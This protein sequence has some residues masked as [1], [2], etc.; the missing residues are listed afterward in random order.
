[1]CPRLWHFH[2][3]FRTENY[4]DCVSS[5]TSCNGSSN[6]DFTDKGDKSPLFYSSK[7]PHIQEHSQ[8]L[9]V[10]VINISPTQRIN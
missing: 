10:A 3:G 8:S 2:N 1:M 5:T 6:Q 9:V 4:C 7:M